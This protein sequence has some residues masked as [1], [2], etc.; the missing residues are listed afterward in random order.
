M[1]KI[2]SLTLLILTNTLWAQDGGI[3]PT[4]TFESAQVLPKGIR[5]VRFMNSQVD[6]IN[7]FND[8]GKT[9]TVGD[10]LN[11]DITWSDSIEGKKTD[12]EKAILKGALKASGHDENEKIGATTGEVNIAVTAQVPVIAYGVS[13]KLTLALAIPVVTTDYSIATGFKENEN[14]EKFAKSELE[15]KNKKH[16]AFKAKDDTLNAIVKKL[17][18]M[19]YEQPMSEKQTRLGDIRLISKYLL[20]KNDTYTLS[21]KGEV[22]APTGE[23]QRT[24]H[25]VDVGTGDGGWDL[26][27]GLASEYNLNDSFTFMSFLGY[28]AQLPTTTERR[29]YE[30]NDSKLTPDVDNNTSVDMGDILKVEGSLKYSFLNGFQFTN[31][32]IYQAKNEDSIN[33]SKYKSNR[34]NWMEAETEQNMHAYQSLIGFSTVP[35]FK[36]K[37]FKVP[38]ETNL[39]YTN[40][41]DG[42]NVIKDQITTF[43]LALFF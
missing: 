22:T 3:R 10:A 43:E 37:K 19:G 7:K 20:T 1:K 6:G 36:Q 8:D 18:D 33:G 26:G 21:V 35:L 42:K 13:E 12:E 23:T 14:L 39:V 32:L 4:M 34:Y 2:T 5:N 40:I 16:K 41:Y 30:K 24:T 25:A 27:V 29:V 15:D 11:K 17:E 38:L 31:G 9:V 28:T